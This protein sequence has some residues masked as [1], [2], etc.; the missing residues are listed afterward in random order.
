MTTISQSLESKTPPLGLLKNVINNGELF[1]KALIIHALTDLDLF[2]NVG[3]S[4]SEQQVAQTADLILQDFK[5]LK[6]EDIKLCFNNAKKGYYGKVY[7]RI[8]GQIVFEW[9]NK[10]SNE[11]AD[12]AEQVSIKS[13]AQLKKGEFEPGEINPE[14]Q[15]KVVEV[16]KSVI[17]NVNVENKKEP[18][19]REMSEN[20]KYFNDILREFDKLYNEN[21]IDLNGQ[22]YVD[23]NG[24]KYSQTEFLEAH[25]SAL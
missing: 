12:V 11:R 21:P 5:H 14:G 2:L 3:K 19:K 24:V 8:D 18:K 25:D 9:L 17:E 15:K 16:L 23:I 6:I 13:H 10:Y 20:Q 7:D 22:R 1:V 4:F